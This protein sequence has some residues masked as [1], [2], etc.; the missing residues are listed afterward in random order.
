MIQLYLLEFHFLYAHTHPDSSGHIEV[1]RPDAVISNIL[2]QHQ[3]AALGDIRS[4]SR[5]VKSFTW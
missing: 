3:H 2:G 5:C 4:S 1:F